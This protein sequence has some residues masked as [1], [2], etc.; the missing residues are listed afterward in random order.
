MKC[1]FQKG[2]SRKRKAE[3]IEPRYL[4]LLRDFIG[5]RV[6]FR[7]RAFISVLMQNGHGSAVLEEMLDEPGYLNTDFSSARFTAQGRPTPGARLKSAP[8]ISSLPVA[9]P[10]RCGR[11]QSLCAARQQMAM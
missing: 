4:V 7:G 8:A 6:A 2:G 10:A 5:R 9:C 11:R 1:H 3:I